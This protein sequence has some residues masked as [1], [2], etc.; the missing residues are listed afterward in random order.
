[1]N[2][3]APN[4]LTEFDDDVRGMIPDR[5]RHGAQIDLH[6]GG[7]L[8]VGQQDAGDLV[9]AVGAQPRGQRFRVD[10]GA[11]WCLEHLDGAAPLLR[12]RGDPLAKNAGRAREEG[13]TR[14]EHVGHR[15]LEAARPR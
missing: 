12:D 3:L 11:P 13:V 4:P 8:V 2:S 14:A 1:M 7:G 6:G 10:P 9:F 5:T 15:R